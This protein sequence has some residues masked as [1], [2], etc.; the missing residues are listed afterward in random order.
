MA[1]FQSILLAYDGSNTSKKAAAAA[2]Q[3]AAVNRSKV[4][5]V[6]VLERLKPVV[7][8][9]PAVY[10][11]PGIDLIQ[12]ASQEILEQSFDLFP[13]EINP[14]LT[15]LRGVPGPTIIEH[16]K[17]IGAD[18]IVIGHR[19]LNRMEEMFLGSV[20]QYVVRHSAMPVLVMKD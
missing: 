2:A 19:G 15:L 13:P 14:R 17:Q 7:T 10:T 11:P 9:E 4:E 5:V 20:G 16:S 8:G 6:H 3:I 18:L 12:D 1:F